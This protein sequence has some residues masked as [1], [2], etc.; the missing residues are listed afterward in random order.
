[1]QIIRTDIA[2]TIVQWTISNS[3]ALKSTDYILNNRIPGWFR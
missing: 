3:F 1:M 2:V